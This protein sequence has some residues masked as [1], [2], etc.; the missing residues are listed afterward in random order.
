[1]MRRVLTLIVLIVLCASCDQKDPAPATPP[2][3]QNAPDSGAAAV[4]S[5]ASEAA[6]KEATDTA[7]LVTRL[8]STIAFRSKREPTTWLDLQMVA[9]AHM[10]RARLLGRYEDYAKAIEALDRAF[11]VA[12]PG[13]GPFQSRASLN[14]TLHRFA[15]AE[16]DLV[17]IE[18][19]AIKQAR[20][21]RFV[22]LTR[23]GIAI[24]R[25]EFEGAKS[26]LDGIGA[27]DGDVLALLAQIAFSTG[28]ADTAR[29]LLDEAIEAEKTNEKVTRAWLLLQRG[30][31]DL[32]TSNLDA[33]RDFFTRADETF[34]GWYLIEEHLTEVMAAQGELEG[35]E[36]RYLD[37]VQRTGLGEFMDALADVYESK[38]DEAKSGEWRAKAGE[39]YA[40]DMKDFPEAV[41][42]HG[43][44][45]FLTGDDTQQALKIAVRNHEVRPGCA[46]K[47]A[48]A[49]AHVR[50]GQLGTAKELTEAA[51]ALGCDTS[52]LH[53][54]AS[55]IH[56]LQGD[57]DAASERAARAE[58]LAS[59]AV[60]DLAWLKP[61]KP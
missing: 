61:L 37:I 7:A 12:K 22:K 52:G 13:T 34:S 60:E 23:A 36:A 10:S 38:G 29:E 57:E 8:D 32:D 47:I 1:M 31:I 50:V 43:L 42:G 39:A 59:G 2:S 16:R 46:S 35:A 48:L 45:H 27:R 14:Y 55:R 44:D 4:E 11:E 5:S 26:L 19:F 30:I 17:A 49:Q 51:G 53:A 41:W 9:D 33:A 21:A 24:Q 54:T 20:D 25:G 18:G 3:S 40:R 6:A 58:A 15:D 56:A 28:D